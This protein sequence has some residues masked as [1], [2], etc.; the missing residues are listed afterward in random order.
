MCVLGP[1]GPWVRAMK[2]LR[3]RREWTFNGG[4]KDSLLYFAFFAV[5]EREFIPLVV[6]NEDWD[7]WFSFLLSVLIVGIA[8]HLLL[9]EGGVYT[10]A[11]M[12][13]ANSQR[14]QNGLQKKLC[15]FFSMRAELWLNRPCEHHLLLI[16]K[17]TTP[18]FCFAVDLCVTTITPILCILQL[19][20][21]TGAKR[22]PVTLEINC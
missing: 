3:E 19:C 20:N 7:V 22:E 6:L 9:P 21:A 14:E 17:H 12:I 13:E 15:F 10:A 18:P 16:L 8:C 11:K 4:V 2:G 5:L 1:S